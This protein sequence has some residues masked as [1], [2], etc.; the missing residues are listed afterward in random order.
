MSRNVRHF[1]LHRI[2]QTELRVVADIDDSGVL[3]II[4]FEET[5]IRAYI[6][7]ANWPHQWVMLYILDDFQPLIRQLRAG[8]NP[9]IL[10]ATGYNLS[11]ESAAV[12]NKRPVVNLFDLSNLT[13]CNVFVNRRAMLEAGYWKDHLAIEALLAHEHAHP[14]A[15]NE[16]T[17]ASRR[18]KIQLDPATVRPPNLYPVLFGLAENLCILAPREIFANQ[19]TIENGYTKALY[20]LNR[21]NFTNVTR[22]VA[23]RKLLLRQ[24]QR[25][26]EA[27]KLSVQEA[28]LLAMGGDLSAHLPLAME[29]APFFRAGRTMEAEKLEAILNQAVFPHLE[30]LTRQAFQALL[31]MYIALQ[32]TAASLPGWVTSVL[33]ILADNFAQKEL[34]LDYKFRLEAA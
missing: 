13:G 28:N 7:H 20:H 34:N 27:G 12:L 9:A 17:R 18:I 31:E 33:N 4:Q 32:P 1:S 14:L 2:A 21:H 23:T 26:I 16:A 25:E 30:L 6:D 22:G 3:P 10:E 29:I 8:V 11:P 5:V 15:E 19:A 24:L